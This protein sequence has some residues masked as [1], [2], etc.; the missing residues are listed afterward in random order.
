MRQQGL[1]ELSTRRL[2]ALGAGLLACMCS[3]AGTA[4]EPHRD[5]VIVTASKIARDLAATPAM[6]S[7]VSGD[8]LR[9]RGANDLRTAL[10]LIAGVD[11][12]PGG[13]V[14]PAGSVP[15]MWGLK[16]FDAFL[17]VV[18]GV[19][20]GGAFNPALST[21]DLTSVDRIEVLR[22]AAPVTFGATS[23]VGVIQ[24]IHA[25]A[26]E[27]PARASVGSGAR[28]TVLVS[29]S[30]DLREHGHLRQSITVNAEKH[31]FS[32]ADSSVGRVHALYRSL[33]ET[34][35]G[36]LHADVDLTRLRQ[37]PYSPHPREGQSLST[38]FT[39]DANVNP[40]DGRQDQDRAQINLRY[41]RKIGG[42]RLASTLSLAHTTTHAARGFLR[43]DFATDGLTPNA[44]GFRQQIDATD[45]YFDSYLAFRPSPTLGWAVGLDCL[46]G[47]GRQRSENFEYAVL[48][49]GSNRP[50]SFSLPV[51]EATRLD[52]E[53]SFG[54]LYTE[55]DWQPTDRWAV[56]A[57]ARLNRTTETRLGVVTPSDGSP[58]A[59]TGERRVVTRFS[60]VAGASYRM[61]SRAVDYV[62]AFADLRSSYKP[63]AVDFGPEAEGDILRPETGKSAELGLRGQLHGGLLTWETSLF[64][65]DFQNLVIRENAGGL[66]GLANAGEERLRGVELEATWSISNTLR[67]TG[68]YAYHDAVFTNYARLQP[69]GSLQQLAGNQLE[70]SPQH[71]AAIGLV[72]GQKLGWV[73]S[74][75]ASRSGSRFL[76][77]TNTAVAGGFTLLD[78]GVGYRWERWQ[79]RVDGINLTDRRDPVAESELGDAQFYRLPGRSVVASVGYEF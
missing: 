74:I 66:P 75:V 68:T 37:D 39:P 73:G 21:L 43:T 52:V 35:A 77:K 78:A 41:E 34:D 57:G 31:R 64:Q 44:D 11:V 50:N 16:E 79:V 27:T 48:P 26:G 55:I 62:T 6:V 42:G 54:G 9:A 19:P 72:R 58:A 10:S 36:T 24:V 56:T 14:G 8:E 7:V 3:S 2:V 32:Q 46:Y 4:E 38:R 61:W 1:F 20:Y 40:L 13:D 30:G 23:F 29:F 25:S 70:L 51:D 15:G 67:L 60:G 76:N 45:A 69:D 63:A 49:D 71:L 33:V 53:R 17:L 12:A 47:K 5:S 28:G 22:G 65:M 59:A 18:D